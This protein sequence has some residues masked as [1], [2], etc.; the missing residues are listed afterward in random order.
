MKYTFTCEDNFSD[1]KSSTEFYAESLDEVLEN[2]GYFLK[3]STFNIDGEVDIVKTDM[4]VSN[5]YTNSPSSINFIVDSLASWNED[6]EKVSGKSFQQ[7]TTCNVCGFP[8]NIMSRHECYHPGCPVS[9][10]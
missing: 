8:N 7:S 4:Q 5:E 6:A 1:W 9:K 3:G 2:F 10:A